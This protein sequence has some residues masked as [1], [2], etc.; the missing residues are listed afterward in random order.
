MIKS[1]M[2]G[3]PVAAVLV[4]AGH[5]NMLHLLPRNTV[6]PDQALLDLI[7]VV[8]KKLE[9]KKLVHRSMALGP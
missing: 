9:D 4:R 5:D 2:S 1:H 6:E 3:L 8:K 7:Y